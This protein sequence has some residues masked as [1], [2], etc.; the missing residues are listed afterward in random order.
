[1]RM[2]LA[3]F[4]V[5]GLSACGSGSNDP[6][7]SLEVTKADKIAGCSPVAHIKNLA[8]ATTNNLEIEIGAGG[9]THLA[10]F[11]NVRPGATQTFDMFSLATPGKTCAEFPTEAKVQRVPNCLVGGQKVADDKCMAAL[12]LESTMPGAVTLTK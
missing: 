6:S 10:T 7:W 11:E 5:L 3:S 4:L 2:L 1:M 9:K 12:K 8:T